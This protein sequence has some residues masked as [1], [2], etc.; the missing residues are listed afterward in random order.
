MSPISA[1]RAAINRTSI[2]PSVLY[3]DNLLMGGSDFVGIHLSELP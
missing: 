2:D 3:A 1:S